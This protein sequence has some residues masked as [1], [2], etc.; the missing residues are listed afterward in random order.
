M[1]SSSLSCPSVIAVR[2][3]V[4]L[5]EN[6]TG[7]CFNQSIAVLRRILFKDDLN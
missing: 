3:F 7:E 4:R 5:K 1:L 6:N 2:F